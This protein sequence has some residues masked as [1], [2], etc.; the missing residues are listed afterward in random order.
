MISATSS[1]ADGHDAAGSAVIAAWSSLSPTWACARNLRE[2]QTAVVDELGE[3]GGSLRRLSCAELRTA[4]ESLFPIYFPIIFR[5]ASL[6]LSC[7]PRP[8]S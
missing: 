5:S 3:N 8:A 4:Q 1:S 7:Q 2:V 6:I